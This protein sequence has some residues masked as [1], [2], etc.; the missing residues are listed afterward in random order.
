[1]TIV[2]IVDR[3]STPFATGISRGIASMSNG[4]DMSRS[5]NDR[6]V[7][8]IVAIAMLRILPITVDRLSSIGI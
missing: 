4:I 6:G 5:M 1:M 3:I 7:M 8:R 2:A